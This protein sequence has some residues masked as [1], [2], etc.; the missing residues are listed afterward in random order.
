[1]AEHPA[2]IVVNRKL[3]LVKRANGLSPKLKKPLTLTDWTSL[4]GGW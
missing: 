1:M 3:F 2:Q 4:A